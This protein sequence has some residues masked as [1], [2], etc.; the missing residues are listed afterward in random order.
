M[1]VETN[2]DHARKQAQYDVNRDQV[3]LTEMVCPKCREVSKP[4]ELGNT[5]KERVC[6]SCGESS[7]MRA[8]LLTSM[9]KKFNR[10]PQDVPRKY[11]AVTMSRKIKEFN[12]FIMDQVCS[13]CHTKGLVAELDNDGNAKIVCYACKQVIFEDQPDTDILHF[14][15]IPVNAILKA[16][17]SKQ[18]V[19]GHTE[20]PI[21]ELIKDTSGTSQI[22]EEAKVT[23]LPDEQSSVEPVKTASA[24]AKLTEVQSLIQTVCR[25]VEELLIEKN[26]KYGNSALEPVRIFSKD[27]PIEAIKVRIDDKLSRLRNE[28]NDEDEDVVTD[29][30][31][32]LVLLKVAQ[33]MKGA[34]K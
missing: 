20:I 18:F 9:N 22:V 25:E 11:S 3:V 17:E 16:M 15:G 8:W 6:P 30:M 21:E 26:R 4:N 34:H 12:S 31:G 29:L 24:P 7:D 14:H 1:S 10:V 19:A 2:M 28:Q 27:D 13:H 32:Y 33:R 5:G 23:E